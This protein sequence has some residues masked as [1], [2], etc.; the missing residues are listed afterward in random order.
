M[1]NF[2][3]TLRKNLTL[4][5]K[6]LWYHLRNRGFLGYKFRR[7][8]QIDDYIADFICFEARIIIEL[9]GRQ[10]LTDEN[11]LYDQKRTEY[12]A[13]QYFRVIR[14]FNTDIL[15]NI[16]LVLEKLKMEL[17]QPLT[18]P[19]DTLSR[20]GRGDEF[21]SKKRNIKQSLLHRREKVVES[22]M[23]VPST[24]QQ[25]RKWVKEERKKLDI[26]GLSSVLVQKLKETDEY[27]QAKNV[28]IFYPLEYEVNLLELLDDTTKSF[29][30]PK[31]NGK[32]LLCCPYKKGD[33]LC[34]SCFKT[35]EP[36]TNPVDESIINLIIVPAL[37]V[38]KNNYR[39][40]YGGGFY[41]RFLEKLDS[42]TIVCLSS[43][44]VLETIYPENNDISVSVVITD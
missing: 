39:L 23:R 12:L 30:L 26:K 35:K 4:P 38:D 8:V 43:R 11:L 19:S 41:D 5:E 10:H 17:E 16:D 21:L 18:R 34:E 33:D 28:M 15:N 42:K 40:G 31:I 3:K 27:K 36:L 37:A 9:D 13:E 2:A 44:L 22:Q 32:N 20:K 1:N 14:F 25:L 24:K 7:Q 29:Y 6:I